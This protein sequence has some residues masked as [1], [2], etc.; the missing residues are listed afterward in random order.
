MDYGTVSKIEKARRYAEQPDRITFN[1]FTVVFRGDNG[2]YTVSLHADGFHCTCPGFHSHHMC[3]HVMTLERL[4]KPMLKRDP[5]PYGPGQNV[6]SDVEKAILYAAEPQ[7]IHFTTLDVTFH[8]DNNEH[9]TV[10]SSEGWECDCGTFRRSGSCS[11]TMA[12]ERILKVM[13]VDEV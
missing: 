11:H 10:L 4:F 9:H 13:V 12:L 6:V 2:S 1:T 5:M 8:G 3:P 7:R